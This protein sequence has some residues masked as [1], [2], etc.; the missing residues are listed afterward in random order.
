LES[1]HLRPRIELCGRLSI[2]LEGRRVED[3]LPGRQGRLLFAYLVL[4]RE[5]PVSRGELIDAIWWQGAPAAPGSALSSHLSRLRRLLGSDRVEGRSELRLALPADAWVDVEAAEAAAAAARDALAARDF[6]RAREPANLVLNVTDRGLLPGHD[7]PW[8]DERRRDLEELALRALECIAEAG[9]AVGGAELGTSERAARRLIQRAP[10]RESGHRYLMQVLESRGDVA[11]ALRVYERLR[12]LLRDELGTAPAAELQSVHARLLGTPGTAGPAPAPAVSHA[13]AMPPPLA[14]GARAPFVG[15][16]AALRQLSDAWERAR[17]G[18]APLTLVAGEAGIGKTRLC[19]EVAAAVHAE[20]AV[21]LYGR[22]DE[23]ALVPYQ[24][25]VEA[26]ERYAGQCD[27]DLLRARVGATGGELARMLPGLRSR[28]PQLAEPVRAQ[29]ETQRYRLFESVRAFL[30]SIGAAGQVLLVLD[31]VHWADAA[32]LRLLQHVRREPPESPLLIVATYRPEGIG[33]EHALP[34]ALA[35]LDRAGAVERLALEGLD[36]DD[37]AAL[38]SARRAPQS[39]Q[40]VRRLLQRTEGNPLFIEATLR[41]LAKSGA[42]D[43]ASA[44]TQL[45]RMGVPEGARETIVAWLSRL[46]PAARSGLAVAAVI[47]RDFEL[48]LLERLLAMPEDSILGLLDECIAAG[49][50]AETPGALDRYAFVHTLIREAAQEQL[51]ASRRARLHGS[52]GAALEELR[53]PDLE[54]YLGALALHFLAAGRA[55]DLRKAVEYA[56]RAADRA[57]AGLAHEEAVVHRE[58]ALRA[59]ALEQPVD[60]D[61]RCELLLELGDTLN[62]AAEVQRARQVFTEAAGVARG[63]DAPAQLARAAVGFGGLGIRLTPGVVDAALVDLLEEALAKLGD[64]EPALRARVMGRLAMELYWIAPTERRSALSRQAVEIARGL[65]PDRATLAFTLSTRHVAIFGPE[66]SRERLAVASEMISVGERMEDEETQVLGHLWRLTD[67]LELGD[68]A[69][70]DAELDAYANLAPRLRRPDY[71]WRIP[72]LRGMRELMHGRFGQAERLAQD[73]REIAE[74]AQD[75]V[76]PHLLAAQT[77]IL[78]REQG[79]LAELEES[80][81]AVV[82]RFPGL[83]AWRCFLAALC[84]ALGHHDE[85]RAEIERLAPERFSSVPRD[86]NWLVALALLSEACAAIGEVSAADE[87]YTVLRPHAAQHVMVGAGAAYFGLVGHHAGVTAATAGRLDQA[88]LH[89]RDAVAA[90][91]LIGARAWLARSQVEYAAALQASGDRD[92]AEPLLAEALVAAAELGMAPTIERAEALRSE[93]L[94]DRVDPQRD[95]G[96]DQ[97]HQSELVAVEGRPARGH[98]PS[99]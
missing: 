39:P 88:R 70:A 75:Q 55:G 83:P 43:D 94:D 49:L 33:A 61:E 6:K 16:S 25:F 78:R 91:E 47:G 87:L 54:P 74:R 79:R 52:V 73:A 58:R 27:A 45:E 41:Q 50:V 14:R 34:R 32:T 26:L 19:A 64:S 22:C 53:A 62:R 3:G 48:D 89:L 46:S 18:D 24:P 97:Q 56:R 13:S 37:V 23:E 1:P 92:R 17:S 67:L 38:V 8:I 30:G 95:R 66:S 35:D 11:E 76:A 15:R 98:R 96:D 93:G 57:S 69:A 4:N 86:G 77:F 36:R 2:E 60:E 20:G 90:H 10:F 68:V 51:S 63:L 12:R 71:L 5:R 28:L 80:V 99:P 59:L 82:A 40:F 84:A 21:V 81:R 72:M 44:E 29:P 7:A 31:D 65:L 85:A 42:P 9:L